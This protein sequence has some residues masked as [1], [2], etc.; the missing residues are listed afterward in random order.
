MTYGR[1][2]LK[3]LEKFNLDVARWPELAAMR[4]AW[5]EMLQTGLAP[6]A[7]RP[8]PSPRIS[9]TKPKRGCT[10]ATNAAIDATLRLERAPLCDLPPTLL[11]QQ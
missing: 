11:N 3:S 8:M 1:G 6:P 10:A 7:F 4:G 2:V 9:R 5:R